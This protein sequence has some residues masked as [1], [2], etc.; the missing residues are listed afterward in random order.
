V[1]HGQVTL[2]LVGLENVY[3][4]DTIGR[5]AG[6]EASY[7][8]HEFE[9]PEPA[10]ALSTFAMT[11]HLDAFDAPRVRQRCTEQRRIGGTTVPRQQPARLRFLECAFHAHQAVCTQ[12]VERVGVLGPLEPREHAA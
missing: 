1:Q 2:D 12:R 3:G 4:G 5:L 11:T 7:I 8:G 6:R 9:R 10:S